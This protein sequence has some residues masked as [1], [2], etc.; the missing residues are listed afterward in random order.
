MGSNYY[1]IRKGKTSIEYS[2]DVEAG[3]SYTVTAQIDGNYSRYWRNTRVEVP[4]AD[5]AYDV[6]ELI[7][8]LK[9]KITGT[10]SLPKTATKN[11][12]T[13]YVQASI[14]Y[15]ANSTTSSY[16]ISG[17]TN[18]TSETTFSPYEPCTRAEAVTFLW[19]NSEC[20]EPTITE[21]PF[22]DVT[23][24]EAYYYKA[25]LWAYENGITKGTSETE[26]SPEETVTRA[27]MIT[28]VYRMTGEKAEAADI[29]FVD[30]DANA[31][32][33]E[34]VMWA[35]TNGVTNGTSETTFSPN[36]QCLRYQVVTFLYRY[37][38]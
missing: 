6:P 18:G 1:V 27:Q 7:L 23:D 26:F 3:Q 30:V 35:V 21:C 24:P 32:Y 17:V 8:P 12:V 20:P 9:A 16:M 10:V 11:A 25:V 34:A 33:A 13:A 22:T 38:Q 14:P 15:S 28:F 31:Y 2:F 19:R 5:G 37:F 4:A 29:P 36:E